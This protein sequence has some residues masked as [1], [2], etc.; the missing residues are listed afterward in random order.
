MVIDHTSLLLVLAL[1][2]A[3]LVVVLVAAW[4]IART[5]RFLITGAI[6]LSVLVAALPV[7]IA[8]IDGPHPF[9]A[10]PAFSLFLIGF[11]IVEGAGW[12]FG[13]GAPPI[14]RIVAISLGAVGL[15]APFFLIGV[16]GL[17]I[18]LVNAL[19]C[20]ILISAGLHYWRS[21][22][23]AP[24]LI[25]MLTGLYA[26]V[27]FS[28][29]LCAVV[30]LVE[31]PLYR[32]RSPNNWAENLNALTSIIGL[33]GIGAISLALNQSRL[34]QRLRVDA[35]TDPLTGLKNR[36]VLFEKHGEGPLPVG[37]AIAIFDLDHFKKVNDEYGHAAGDEVLKHF[38]KL[39]ERQ[40][41]GTM[42]AART[43]GEEFVLV[44]QNTSVS[45]A[46]VIVDRI[47]EAF[48]QSTV[49]TKNGPL[50]CTV[51]VGLSFASD[52]KRALDAVMHEADQALYRAKR[53]GRNR[54]AVSG[55]P[56]AA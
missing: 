44:L 6:G 39:L 52:S 10:L 27:G 54:V 34:V 20:V 12:Q 31:S 23:E 37:T 35:G 26:L 32:V 41:R 7:F 2:S 15:T 50:N 5:D 45:P 21:R 28:F 16:D 22:Q 1:L 18:S 36:R 29:L 25:S 3:C 38:S 4:T 48:A 56:T 43:G 30:I 55:L 24:T 51:S 49:Q 17:G 40:T 13:T 8:Y 46:Q 47:R 33:A 19:A 42:I 53:N 14:R 11:S 9:L